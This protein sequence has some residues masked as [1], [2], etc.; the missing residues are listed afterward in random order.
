MIGKGLLTAE[1]FSLPDF[2]FP[3]IDQ[4]FEENDFDPRN[5]NGQVPLN[6]EEAKRNLRQIF[7][8]GLADVLKNRNLPIITETLRRIE[9]ALDLT[10][11]VIGY[12]LIVFRFPFVPVIL[13]TLKD[14]L[15]KIFRLIN[16][17]T[18]L[19]TYSLS[20]LLTYSLFHYLALY[21][22]SFLTLVSLSKA[23]IF[24]PSLPIILPLTSSLGTVIVDTVYSAT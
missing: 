15:K 4:V 17:P 1:R 13:P 5:G 7:Y 14:L 22:F 11:K 20:H 19:F 23:L 24:L 3:K 10:G 18:T 9:K 6:F 21:T 2:S 16:Q 12:P 8:S